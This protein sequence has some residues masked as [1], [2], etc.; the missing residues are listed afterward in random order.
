MVN[1]KNKEQKPTTSSTAVEKKPDSQDKSTDQK[2]PKDKKNAKPVEEDLVTICDLFLFITI[3]NKLRIFKSDEDKL[4]KDEL[5]L[6]VQRLTEPDSRLYKQALEILRVRIKE[7]TS[8]MT[9]VPKPLKFLRE[10]YNTIKEAYAKISDKE[11][12]VN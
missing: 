11:T 2:D 4:L 7:S 3:S 6:C 5:H 1:D 10:H 8:S 9:S 12:K